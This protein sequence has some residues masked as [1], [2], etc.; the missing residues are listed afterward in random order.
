[1]SSPRRSLS[2]RMYRGLLRVY[3]VDFRKG[4]GSDALELFRD[5]LR[6]ARASGGSLGVAWLWLRTIPNVLLH[7]VLERYS[8]Y[9]RLPSPD[10][11]ATLRGAAR[12][13]VRSPG[14]SATIVL[15]LGV[16]VGAVVALFSLLRG[17]ILEPLPYP[18]A[19]R[20]V[21]LWETNPDID[22]DPVGP[23]PL[24]FADWH[25]ASPG[26]E[27]MA[28]WYLTS[29][30]YRGDGWA[31]EIRS[32]Q[33]TVDFFR[34]LGVPPMLGRDFRHEEVV[35]YGPL[36]LS[37]RVWL[38]RFGGD[39]D[40]V[41]QTVVSSG[42][43]YEIVGVMPPE[44]TFP[45]E[46]VETWVAWDL[47]NVYRDRPEARTWRF[48]DGIGRLAPATSIEEAEEGLDAVAA[49]L[50]E[51]YPTMNEGWG[52]AVTSL[53]EETVGDVRATLWLAFG[54]V[55]FILLIACANVANLLLAR[56]PTRSRELAI[57]TT[58]GASRGRIARELLTESLILA[59][60]SS[61]VGL[62]LGVAL[63]DLLVALDA[64]R[65]PRLGEVGI[66][67]G[68]V[69]FTAALAVLT[70]IL[71]GLVPA[72]QALRGSVSSSLGDGTR[73][74]STASQ[75]RVREVFVASQVAIALV[76]LT[77]AGL[78]SA[79]LKEVMNVDPGIEV[80]DVAT[81]RVS[82]D[83]VEGTA[84]ETA[85]YFESLEARLAEVPGVTAVGAAQTLPLN[86]VG[87]DFRRPYRRFGSPLESADAP[88]VQMR[89]V[90]PG[91][92]DAIGMKLLAGGPIPE[93]A[94][95][96]EPLVAVVNQ[97][98]ARRLWPRGEAVGETLEIDFRD[99]WQ[100][101]TVVG[102]LQDVRHYGLRAETQPEVF[103]AHR[104]VPYL[105]MSLV[106]KTSGEAGAM[107]EALRASVL[108]HVPMQPPHHFVTLDDLLSASIAEERFL[109][110]LLLVFAS[111]GLALATT[112]VYGVIAYSVNHRRGEIGVRMALGAPPRRVV[113]GVFSNAL[114]IA[115]A[116][117]VVGLGAV[118]AL[119]GLVE[120]LLF[121]V[122]PGDL[123]TTMLVVTV[124][125]VASAVA[126]YVPA[127][128]AARVAPAEALRAD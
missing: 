63:I 101:Y 98:L 60:A 26:L 54:A 32:A 67:S 86:P 39:P 21:R 77:G 75:R 82:L 112:G 4:Y 115:G 48:L 120:G 128:I 45:D 90:T 73:T 22:A 36:M 70:S 107:T 65:I 127:R 44:F 29:G 106:V 105:A 87:N 47:P 118:A 56:V 1:V 69:A 122:S 8:D 123:R 11:G 15:T 93:S 116:G 95:L 96:G 43:T 99:G 18:A 79:S 126:A 113:T 20:L 80:A 16:G 9:R 89:I 74:S 59:V 84:E 25:R 2:E 6:E 10:R 103:L 104:Q 30:T 114:T 78:F 125:L 57:H 121:G 110:V 72:L 68:V 81:F 34:V 62:L 31:E 85:R 38:R 40:V 24:N 53:H 94:A 124:L 52:A 27:S 100:P 88:T 61:G 51:A 83:P 111:I 108:S 50:A 28:A 13:L 117:M 46:S 66:D 91:Y 14:L 119:S 102:V 35:R 19:D 64:G 5:R 55:L 42:S 97:T 41:G 7:G 71:F 23:S 49:G 12:T 37:H 58:L 109:S 33:V 76:L 17:V 92:V 3:P